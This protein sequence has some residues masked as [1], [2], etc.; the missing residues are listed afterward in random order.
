MENTVGQRIEISYNVSGANPTDEDYLYVNEHVD[1]VDTVT[2]KEDARTKDSAEI[3]YHYV[4]GE[5]DKLDRAYMVIEN[6]NEYGESFSYNDDGELF[7]ITN[8]EGKIYELTY[9][10]SGRVAMVNDPVDESYSFTYQASKTIAQD[11][12]GVNTSYE[13]DAEGRVTKFTD[14]LGHDMNYTFNDNFQ[15]TGVSYLNTV[16]GSTTPT[17]ISYTYSYDEIKWKHNEH[18]RP[19]RQP[20]GI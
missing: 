17:Q 6:N 8:P 20:D 19:E 16:D 2:W 13:F 15:V 10:A 14:A 12:R 11:K 4:Y 7:E 5:D 9:D 18:I 3:V 1:M